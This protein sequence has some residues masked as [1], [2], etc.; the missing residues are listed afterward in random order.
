[1]LD[2]KSMFVE[3]FSNSVVAEVYLQICE[4]T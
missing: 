1:M 4:E 3:Y 2:F